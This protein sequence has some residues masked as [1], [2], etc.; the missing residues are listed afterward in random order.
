MDWFEQVQ[1]VTLYWGHIKERVLSS[2]DLLWPWAWTTV[3]ACV[4]VRPL[5]AGLLFGNGFTAVRSH[6]TRHPGT[7]SSEESGI[8][9]KGWTFLPREMGCVTK[10]KFRW[11]G[12]SVRHVVVWKNMTLFK[13]FLSSHKTCHRLSRWCYTIYRKIPSRYRFY[14]PWYLQ[15]ISSLNLLTFKT[16]IIETIALDIFVAIVKKI[17]EIIMYHL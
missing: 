15:I 17:V 13:S 1:S 11:D 3:R 9:E 12:L 2:L 16:F 7:L 4:A 10:E 14:R 6:D 8:I 5:R